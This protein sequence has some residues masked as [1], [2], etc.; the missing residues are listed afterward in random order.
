MPELRTGRRPSNWIVFPAA[1]AA[2]LAL[3]VVITFPLILHL[4][5]RVPM[6]LEDSLW[7]VTV[8]W[9]NAHVTPLT[10]AWWNGFA[11]YPS[12]G[13]MAFSDHML[14]ASLIASPR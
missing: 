14:G 4:P 7:Y 8:L 1:F 6:D 11:F 2:Y 5:S 12:V 10:A 3:A 13:M 9:W